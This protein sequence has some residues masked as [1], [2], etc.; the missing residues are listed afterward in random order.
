[1]PA[2]ASRA[3]AEHVGRSLIKVDLDHR[4]DV[5]AQFEAEVD[6]ALLQLLTRNREL[7]RRVSRDLAS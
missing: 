1:M 4:V 3:L 6:E 7:A 2:R 5:Q